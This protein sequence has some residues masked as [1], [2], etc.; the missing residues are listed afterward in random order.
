MRSRNF[1]DEEVNKEYEKLSDSNNSYD[2][3]PEHTFISSCLRIGLSLNDLKILSYIDVMKII[4]SFIDKGEGKKTN[5]KMA[6]QADWDNL[7][8]T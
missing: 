6:T 1:V 8:I 4:L 2:P 7:A 5:Y 3:F